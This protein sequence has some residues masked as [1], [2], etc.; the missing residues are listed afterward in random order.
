MPTAT[1]KKKCCVQC[2]FC[3]K[4]YMSPSLYQRHMSYCKKKPI[5]KSPTPLK[6]HSGK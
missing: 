2:R 4:I 3:E 6:S 5:E 1:K